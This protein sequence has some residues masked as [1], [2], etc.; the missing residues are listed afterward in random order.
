MV[1]SDFVIGHKVALHHSCARQ[2]LAQ[3]LP[4]LGHFWSYIAPITGKEK[5]YQNSQNVVRQKMNYYY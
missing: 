1:E 5:S 2:E 4:N 3:S